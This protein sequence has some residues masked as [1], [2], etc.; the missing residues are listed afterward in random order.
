LGDTITGR[1]PFPVTRLR[2]VRRTA[3]LRAL[4]RETRLDPAALVLPM[5]VV[6]GSGRRE[7][8][9]TF[10]GVAHLSPDLA[11]AE[12]K[13]AAA[14]GVGG[15]LLFG[16]PDSKDAQGSSAWDDAGPV[17][18]AVRAIREAAPEIVIATDVCLCQYTDHG[19]CGVLAEDGEISNDET[20]PLLAR[21]AVS[22]ARAGADLIAPSDMMD[23]RIGAVRSALDDA[24]L[25]E[26]AAIMAYSSKF[27]SAFYGPFRDAA[28]SAPQRGDRKSYQADPANVRA[29]IHESLLD[30]EEGAD[31]V[32]VKPAGPY[33]DVIERLVHETHVPIAA[34]QVSGEHAMLRFAAQA[35]ALDLQAATLES[36]IAIRRAGAQ[37]IMTY[38]AI[39]VA[40]WLS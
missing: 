25:A 29:A 2:R 37:V 22:H 39:E 27:S 38:S 40:E 14:A 21:V 9:A 3:G 28:H 7:P 20:L 10:P 23:G 26:R 12:A 16:L 1:M 5:F 17:Q 13:R 32:M 4:V 8:V 30:V 6:T 35:G 34:Y 31:I 36:L 11:A 33:L 24:G 18:T 15:V 19:H